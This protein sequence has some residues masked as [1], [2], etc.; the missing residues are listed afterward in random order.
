M[1]Y[2]SGSSYL[3]KCGVAASRGEVVAFGADCP[4]CLVPS[5]WPS[6]EQQVASGFNKGKLFDKLLGRQT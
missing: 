6:A 4:A 5:A 2:A 1:A 3:T